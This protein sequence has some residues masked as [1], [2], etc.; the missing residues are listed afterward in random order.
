MPLIDKRMNLL[1][2]ENGAGIEE[3]R[4]PVKA[5]YRKY[6][7]N[8]AIG[9]TLASVLKHAPYADNAAFSTLPKLGVITNNQN[10]DAGPFFF[11]KQDWPHFNVLAVPYIN[12]DK[13]GTGEELIHAI[14]WLSDRPLNQRE[15][16]QKAIKSGNKKVYEEGSPEA[17][18]MFF[19]NLAQDTD[20]PINSR[21][22]YFS[23]HG[24]FERD[25]PKLVGEILHNDYI[26]D[27]FLY[28]ESVPRLVL[29]DPD[30]AQKY[31]PEAMKELKSFFN[32]FPSYDD[33]L[34]VR[35]NY[36]LSK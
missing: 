20:I 10:Q 24:G 27:A 26:K 30:T 9:L 19:D 22:K 15:N 31:Y 6:P 28:S 34:E 21:A 2:V 18:K 3:Y 8:R 13:Q 7:Q 29:A 17:K 32:E 16:Y 35:F 33:D 1:D 14:D 5:L 12:V 23:P 36:N 25:V 11:I 4:G